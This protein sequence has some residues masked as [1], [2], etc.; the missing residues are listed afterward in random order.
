[1]RQF[2][3]VVALVLAYPLVTTAQKSVAGAMTEQWNAAKGNILASADQMPEAEFSF[4]P[5]PAVRSFGA[6]LAHLAGANYVFCAAASGEKP[7]YS[8]D[9]FEKTTKTKAEIVKA[10]KESVGYCDKAYSAAT[11]QNL[12]AP[13]TAPFGGGQQ[14]RA[15]VLLGN[16]GHQQEHYGNLVTYFRLKG[17][18]PPSSRGQ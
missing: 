12:S 1:M 9:H 17:M 15:S 6:I 13:V 4:A 8:E 10:L 5:T 14:A 16:I 7:P 18:T 2:I 11:D 3:L